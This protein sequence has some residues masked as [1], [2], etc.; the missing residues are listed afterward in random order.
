[1]T[2]IRLWRR[3][4]QRGNLVSIK[5]KEV[6][7]TGGC[8]FIG[9]NLAVYLKKKYPYLK[10][11]SLD[12]LVRRGSE[13][14]VKRLK[15]NNIEFIKGDVRKSKDLAKITSIDL[16]IECSAEPSVSAGYKESPRYVLDTN[17]FGAVNC[18]E[19]AREKK[20]DIIFLSTSR[21]Y[22]YDKINSL[23]IVKEDSRFKWQDEQ[24]IEIS[25]WSGEGIDVDFS[26]EG[27]RSMYGATKLCAEIIL[28]EYINM[29]GLQ[30]LINRCGVIGGPWQFGKVDQG[31]FSL[32]M[33]AHYFKRPLNY[34]GFDGEGRQV[35]DL[36]HIDDFCELID[37][38]INSL[39][40]ISGQIYNVGGG[41]NI[42]LSL[43]EATQLCEEISGNKI[44]IT[45]K[46]DTRPADLAVYITDNKKVTSQLNWQP[47]KTA[48]Q[49]LED[50]YQWIK[51]NE[52]Q[53][54]KL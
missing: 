10:I 33:L 13:L 51:D 30:G 7:I 8:G 43:R 29:Y 44:N 50:I 16:L 37:I 54:S 22:P 2:Y 4:A 19:L 40:K 3:F 20:A 49:I 36:L 46:K 31:V 24:G 12:N 27:V 35:R 6:L 5:Y 39:D 52:K 41:K 21:I 28:K 18:F 45:A 11:V 25:G 32:W 47:K 1:M 48:R 9:S 53:L 34:I 42:S 23:R 26:L 17:L 15:E 38:Q 14:N